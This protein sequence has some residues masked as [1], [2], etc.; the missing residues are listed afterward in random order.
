MT[1]LIRKIAFFFGLP[2]GVAGRIIRLVRATHGADT[3]VS[4]ADEEESLVYY[5]ER[6]SGALSEWDG[7][8]ATRS[9]SMNMLWLH[10]CS[11]GYR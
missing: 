11:Y 4:L 2:F 7:P 3:F 8:A 5:G 10:S 1:A 6:K 9:V